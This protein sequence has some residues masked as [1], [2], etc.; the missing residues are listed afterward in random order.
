MGGWEFGGVSGL[1]SVEDFVGW[2]VN[3]DAGR[4][5]NGTRGDEKGLRMGQSRRQPL[6]M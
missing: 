2:V 6:V 5:K 4:G 1:F 3:P